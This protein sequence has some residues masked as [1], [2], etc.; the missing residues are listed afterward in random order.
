[1]AN[2]NFTSIDKLC[3]KTDCI[4]NIDK[5]DKVKLCN[6]ANAAMNIAIH[7]GPTK[8]A[9]G[10]ILCDSRAMIEQ[11]KKKNKKGKKTDY[12]SAPFWI[13]LSSG[14]ELPFFAAMEIVDF[15]FTEKETVT[16]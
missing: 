14:A 12:T 9:E 10:V 6:W 13:V 1:M 5:N 4:P 2:A 7:R 3:D 15:L 11:Q 8:L 16:G